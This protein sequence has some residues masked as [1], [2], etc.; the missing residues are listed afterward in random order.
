MRHGEAGGVPGVYPVLYRQIAQE[1]T[2]HEQRA[3]WFVVLQLETDLPG[4]PFWMPEVESAFPGDTGE[5]GPIQGPEG[6]SFIVSQVDFLIPRQDGDRIRIGHSRLQRS[7]QP[8][9]YML[10]QTSSSECFL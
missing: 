5:P 4:A 3:G 6:R 1:L 7:Y 8:A 9:S 2:V 10:S